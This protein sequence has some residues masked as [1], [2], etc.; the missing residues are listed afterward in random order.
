MAIDTNF[1][2]FAFSMQTHDN[3]DAG[4]TS[5]QWRPDND[6]YEVVNV[7]SEL[8]PVLDYVYENFRRQDEERR[9]N[10]K[11]NKAVAEE[12]EKW[13]DR[14]AKERKNGSTW[15]TSSCLLRS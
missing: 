4:L 11:I 15:F 6:R 12:R 10:D 3:R 13:I 5:D 8:K 7:L 2:R 1:E 14:L 9:Q